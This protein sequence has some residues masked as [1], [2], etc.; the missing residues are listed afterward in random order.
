MRDAKRI[1]RILNLLRNVWYNFPDWRLGQLLSNIAAA[2]GYPVKDLFYFD[3]D[4]LERVLRKMA[5]EDAKDHL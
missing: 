5:K 3:D 2:D 1:E 4:R